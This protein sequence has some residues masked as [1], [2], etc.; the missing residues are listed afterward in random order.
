MPARRESNFEPYL[1]C[2][3]PFPTL[4]RLL[5]CI[6]GEL[7][8]FDKLGEAWQR[9][10]SR[11][12]LYLAL[13][14]AHCAVADFLARRRWTMN[15]IARRLPPIAPAIGL[16]EALLNA[17]WSLR[18]AWIAH[19]TRGWRRLLDQEIDLVCDILVAPEVADR[20]RWLA[21]C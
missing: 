2:L 8:R 3:D 19:C 16:A 18:R 7:D 20:A 10:E 1:W 11:V 13:A 9:V 6:A 15:S 21:L 12:N 4:R 5:A 14:A 17:P